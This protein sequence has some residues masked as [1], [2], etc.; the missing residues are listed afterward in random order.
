MP[1]YKRATR[2]TLPEPTGRRLEEMAEEREM[3]LDALISELV[4]LGIKSLE[5]PDQEP[6]GILRGIDPSDDDFSA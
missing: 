1:K 2:L 5:Y 6:E 4:L 3:S